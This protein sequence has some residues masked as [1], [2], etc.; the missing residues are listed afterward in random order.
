MPYSNRDVS[1]D[2]LPST[3]KI[4]VIAVCFGILFTLAYYS[5]LERERKL[6]NTR[7][8]KAIIKSV[9]KTTR[10]GATVFFNV[11]DRKL[12]AIFHGGD[13]KFL[14]PGDTILIKYAIEEPELIDVVD[15]YYMKKHKKIRNGS[16]STR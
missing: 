6:K 2:K 11:K 14:S 10:G 1:Q 13:F 12:E 15:K 9:R 4:V 7:Q 8:V 5:Q 3:K 16:V